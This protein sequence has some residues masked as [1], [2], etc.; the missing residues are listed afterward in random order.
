LV[1]E[2]VIGQVLLQV[3]FI[4]KFSY[5]I[6]DTNRISDLEIELQTQ[7]YRHRENY[8]HNYSNKKQNYRIFTSLKV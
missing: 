8:R 5:R 1:L 4:H 7:N 3:T 6:T 2:G